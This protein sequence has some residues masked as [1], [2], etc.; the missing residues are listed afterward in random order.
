MQF[1]TVVLTQTIKSE[2]TITKQPM[3]PVESFLNTQLE[4]ALKHVG[5]IYRLHTGGI[6]LL[7]CTFSF[8]FAN[9]LVP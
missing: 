5:P 1:R 7:V 6:T 4:L 9:T 2:D 3:K 8:M